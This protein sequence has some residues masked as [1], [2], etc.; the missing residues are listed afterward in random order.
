MNRF[1]AL[2][3]LPLALGVAFAA[4]RLLREGRRGLVAAG[5]LLCFVEFAPE[6]PG[7]QL[8]PFDPPDP[9]MAAIASSPAPGVVL[10]IDPG[11][12]DL[13]HQLLHGRPQI[14]GCL[15]RTPPLAVARR[16][17]DPVIGPLLGTAPSPGLP[18]A[19]SA[20][21]LSS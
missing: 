14:L 2:A 9:P 5:A 11:N 17:A 10:D 15:S 16:L 4:T 20:A 19:V 13:I 18:P 21:W 6:D 8:W 7:H 12:L 3:S 1:Q